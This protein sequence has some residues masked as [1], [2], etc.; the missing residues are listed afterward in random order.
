MSEHRSR[1]PKL[2]KITAI[3]AHHDDGRYKTTT[4][5]FQV[6]LYVRTAA[7]GWIAVGNGVSSHGIK[8]EEDNRQRH[9]HVG[10]LPELESADQER[11]G[12]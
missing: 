1:E 10:R 12:K 6:L 11:R 9:K 3:I 2:A 4:A 7:G 5:S 8:A